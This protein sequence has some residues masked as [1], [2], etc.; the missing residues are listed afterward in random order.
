MDACCLQV[1]HR[2]LVMKR[3]PFIGMMPMLPGALF[4]MRRMD[5]RAVTVLRE[6]GFVL[7]VESS[8]FAS[9]LGVHGRVSRLMARMKAADRA[10]ASASALG[11]G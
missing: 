11:R 7:L 9:M 8:A 3:A 1:I 10:S 5:V 2:V 4:V 6:I